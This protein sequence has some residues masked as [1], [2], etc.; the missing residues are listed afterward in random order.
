MEE[1]IDNNYNTY[2]QLYINNLERFGLPLYGKNSGFGQALSFLSS[3]MNQVV[4]IEKIKDYVS[5]K[6]I[7]LKGGDSLQVRHI[8]RNGYN[9]LKGGEMHPITN[10]KLPRSHFCLVNL[11]E[12]H[13]SYNPNVNKQITMTND[14][15]LQKKQFYNNQCASC[16]NIEGQPMRFNKYAL[17]VLQR[18]HMDPRK[19][20]TYDN[21]IPQCRDCNQQYLNKAIFNAQGRVIDWC[22]TGFI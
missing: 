9:L 1:Q 8:A 11:T 10:E 15:W 13:P 4:S 16:G 21:I 18:G 12:H 22:K 17:T 5:S 2:H 6:G 14:D 7:L 19:E 20:G 3:N